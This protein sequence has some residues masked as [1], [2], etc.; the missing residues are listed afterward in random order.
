MSK[1][2]P[3]KKDPELSTGYRDLGWTS[4][5]AGSFLSLGESK[6][7]RKVICELQKKLYNSHIGCCSPPLW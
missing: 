2:W 4:F 7:G 1:L 5:G 6:G 3:W